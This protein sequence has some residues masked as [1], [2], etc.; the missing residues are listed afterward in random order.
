MR[1]V[2]AGI[3]RQPPRAIHDLFREIADGAKNRDRGAHQHEG[4]APDAAIELLSIQMTF[5]N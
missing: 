5:H 1:I 2:A 3:S 4:G